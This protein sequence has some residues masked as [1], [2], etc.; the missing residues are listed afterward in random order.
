MAT[1]KYDYL[2]DNCLHEHPIIDSDYLTNYIIIS[3]EDRLNFT[4]TK[5]TIAILDIVLDTFAKNQPCIPIVPTNVGKLNLQNGIGH[6]SRIE[7]RA[8]EKVSHNHLLLLI[9]TEK[10]H[11]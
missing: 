9:L 5:N 3:A 2:D 8:E 7:L 4:V 10:K 6:A 11:N 1:D